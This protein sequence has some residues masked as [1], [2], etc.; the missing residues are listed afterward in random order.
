MLEMISPD[1]QVSTKTS[2]VTKRDDTFGNLRCHVWRLEWGTKPPADFQCGWDCYACFILFWEK[3]PDALFALEVL[4]KSLDF[5][6]RVQAVVSCW[7]VKFL[8]SHPPQPNR[9]FPKTQATL[10]IEGLAGEIHLCLDHHVKVTPFLTEQPGGGF[11]EANSWDLKILPA[12]LAPKN[13]VV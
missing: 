13:P 4:G 3:S 7:M 2:G 11:V 6:A 12:N 10:Q 5:G 9:L 1:S 8:M